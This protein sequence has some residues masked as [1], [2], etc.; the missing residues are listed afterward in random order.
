MVILAEMLLKIKQI[1][2]NLSVISNSTSDFLVPK[3]KS[4]C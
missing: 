3:G 1:E 4:H 2:K